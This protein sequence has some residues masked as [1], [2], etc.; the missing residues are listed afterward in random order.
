METQTIPQ[1]SILQTGKEYKILRVS[2]E[3]GSQMPAHFCTKEAIIIV[4]EGIALLK[5]TAQDIH[6]KKNDSAIIPAGE[7]HTLIVQENFQATVIMGIDSDIKF[8]NK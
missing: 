7:L 8:A 2:G 3:K 4:Q 5:L 6:L 1:M